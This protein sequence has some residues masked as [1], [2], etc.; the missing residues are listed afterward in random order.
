MRYESWK[1]VA[2][3]AVMTAA[4]YVAFTHAQ[5][6]ADAKAAAVM[7]DCA[8]RSAASRSWRR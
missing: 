3:L 4:Y 6:Q 1:S 8:R 7:A 2:V 5:A